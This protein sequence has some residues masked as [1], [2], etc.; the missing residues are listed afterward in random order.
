MYNYDILNEKLPSPVL[1]FSFLGL[2]EL[3]CFH[4]FE[5]NADRTCEVICGNGSVNGPIQ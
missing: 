5:M 2:F 4:L 3:L 1:Y